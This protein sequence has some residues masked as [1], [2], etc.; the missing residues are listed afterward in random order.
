MIVAQTMKLLPESVRSTLVGVE[1]KV[2]RRAPK[3]WA[4]E[5]RASF[6]GWPATDDRE[7][8]DEGEDP[9]L[10][11]GVLTLAADR[12]NLDDDVQTTLV[13]ELAHALG[14]DETDV[15]L[16][17]LSDKGVADAVAGSTADLE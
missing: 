5:D 11:D 2:L 8:E 12:F 17:G 16:M 13:H 4:A 3:G 6:Q 15:S 14:F 9:E 10:P 7:A 1:I